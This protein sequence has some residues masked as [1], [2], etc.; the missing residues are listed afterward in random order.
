ML[1][2]P[3]PVSQAE[4]TLKRL[5]ARP[6]DTEYSDQIEDRT[7][8]FR[9][10]DAPP[11]YVE[12]YRTARRDQRVIESNEVEGLSYAVILGDVEATL[13]QVPEITRWDD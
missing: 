10:S 6:I 1:G 9:A 3:D 12:R 7:R 11:P 13:R 2:Q 8:Q 4:L 5:F